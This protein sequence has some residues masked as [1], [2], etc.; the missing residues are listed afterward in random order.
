MHTLM[1]E[2]LLAV[3][4]AALTRTRTIT[5]RC[6]AKLTQRHHV[7]TCATAHYKVA[8]SSW[9][10]HYQATH[11]VVYSVCYLN[12]SADV[13]VCFFDVSPFKLKHFICEPAVRVYRAWHLI[14]TR[15]QRATATY[16]LS[17]SSFSGEQRFCIVANSSNSTGQPAAMKQR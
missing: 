6:V 12:S 5:L 14:V 1:L 17:T 4:T 3:A 13:H 15:Q 10:S 9:M 2:K 16:G 8:Q 7:C 11:N